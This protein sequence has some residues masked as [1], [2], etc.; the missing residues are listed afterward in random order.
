MTLTHP[1]LFSK[2]HKFVVAVN[3]AKSNPVREAQQDAGSG[4][5]D[6]DEDGAPGTHGAKDLHTDC[7][8]V[9]DQA[10]GNAVDDGVIRVDEDCAYLGT[11]KFEASTDEHAANGG[12]A[13]TLQR[14]QWKSKPPPPVDAE[15]GS[16]DRPGGHSKLD[17]IMFGRS[18]SARRESLEASVGTPLDIVKE[19]F[20][21]EDGDGSSPM[22]LLLRESNTYIKQRIA[23]RV[24]RRC[25]KT[26]HCNRL[27]AD[28]CANPLPWEVGGLKANAYAAVT[29]LRGTLHQS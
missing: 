16:K 19:P 12:E 28:L 17:D 8:E 4:D 7:E 11:F 15:P 10:G 22:K 23:A 3:R 13:P 26:L 21:R 29:L 25:A 24:I 1:L 20:T 5:E 2:A 27:C 18:R 9:D 6:G 14:P